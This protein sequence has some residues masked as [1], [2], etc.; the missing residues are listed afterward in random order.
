LEAESSAYVV[1]R[2]LGIDS[3]DYSFG[4]VTAWAGGRD[5]ALAGI[6]ASGERIQRASATIL[7]AF[8]PRVAAEAA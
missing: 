8:E 4:Y 6:R 2:A 7:S 1:C 5:E 3:G